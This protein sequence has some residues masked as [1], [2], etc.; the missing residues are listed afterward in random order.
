[1]AIPSLAFGKIG[2]LKPPSR[3]PLIAAGLAGVLLIAAGLFLGGEDPAESLPETIGPGDAAPTGSAVGGAEERLSQPKRSL[4]AAPSQDS[5][6]APGARL[7]PAEMG[8]TSVVVQLAFKGEDTPAAGAQI[9]LW[10]EPTGEGA[11]F[12]P[13]RRLAQVEADSQGLASLSAVPAVPLE[14][15]AQAPGAGPL[16]RQRIGTLE[17]EETRTVR[18]ELERPPAPMDLSVIASDSG[19]PV[20][21]A[22][23]RVVM[24]DQANLG[25]EEFPGSTKLVQ[26]TDGAGSASL[27]GPVRRGTWLIV[28]AAGFSPK[29]IDLRSLDGLASPEVILERAGKVEATV[30]DGA[31]KPLA[32]IEV[33]LFARMGKSVGGLQTTFTAVTNRQG[34]ANFPRLPVGTPLVPH[35]GPVGEIPT[36]FDAFAL[37]PGEVHRL[38]VEL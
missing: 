29:A 26:R 11:A 9:S 24:T 1:M 13:A 16:A 7:N 38:E 14:I 8:P 30:V 27:P 23:I 10:R 32:D 2:P 19:E 17:P 31:G 22:A 15:Y 33:Q 3:L 21:G 18:L 20:P 5:A 4:K 28:D 34:A 12:R 37:K 6:P 35:V 36:L 25:I